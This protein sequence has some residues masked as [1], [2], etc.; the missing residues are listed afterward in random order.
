M[1]NILK[2][3][4][5]AIKALP[6]DTSDDDDDDDDDEVWQHGYGWRY[7]GSQYGAERDHRPIPGPKNSWGAGK[8]SGY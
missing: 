5:R 1:R 7:N 2:K 3:L 6:W 8:G 4:W